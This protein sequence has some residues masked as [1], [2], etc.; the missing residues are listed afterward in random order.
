MPPPF[1]RRGVTRM[2]QTMCRAQA[3]VLT[4]RCGLSNSITAKR[5]TRCESFD[6]RMSRCAKEL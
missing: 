6:W 5:H 2:A 3:L 1:R 4:H